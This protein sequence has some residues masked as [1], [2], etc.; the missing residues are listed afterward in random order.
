MLKVLFFDYRSCEQVEGFV[1]EAE[2]PLKHAG[3][4]VL[5]SDQPLAIAHRHYS[6]LL[7]IYPLYTMNWE[8]PENG[9]IIAR[10]LDQWIGLR[11][12]HGYSFRGAS[13]ISASIGRRDAAVRLLNAM[14]DSQS[15]P[16]TMYIEW[17]S[18]GCL[19]IR[20]GQLV[21]LPQGWFPFPRQPTVALSCRPPRAPST[22]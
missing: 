21:R 1:C 22:V 2:P 20:H 14:L 10:S 8:Q 3:N 4:P 7:M 16:N 6:H 5:V 18:P 19:A 9:D 13:S 15:S 11:G 17:A 12:F